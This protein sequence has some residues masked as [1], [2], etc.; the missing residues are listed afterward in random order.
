MTPGARRRGPG[1]GATLLRVGVRSA[2]SGRAAFAEARESRPAYPSPHGRCRRQ[3]RPPGHARRAG[4]VDR[5]PDRAEADGA[6]AGAVGEDARPRARGRRRVAGHEE[7][8]RDPRHRRRARP[9]PPGRRGGGAAAARP[10]PLP[11]G[12]PELP[13]G[14]GRGRARRVGRG[15]R[16]GARARAPPPFPGPLA[17]ADGSP[18]GPL[19]RL[20]PRGGARPARREHLLEARRRGYTEGSAIPSGP[21]PTIAARSRSTRTRSTASTRWARRWSPSASRRRPSATSTTRSPAR[22]G[23]WT[24]T[25]PARWRSR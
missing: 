2:R 9:A 4:L 13:A 12:P 6:P 20:R 21:S 5:R 23:T 7:A 8:A 11:P 19:A 16:R 10:A 24:S 17:G 14:R 15:R 3:G 18:A 1:E 25:R 22:R